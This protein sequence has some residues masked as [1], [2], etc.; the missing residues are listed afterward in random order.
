RTFAATSPLIQKFVAEIP[1]LFFGRCFLCWKY[2]LSLSVIILK[3]VLA[4]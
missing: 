2:S 1:C 4:T 3:E